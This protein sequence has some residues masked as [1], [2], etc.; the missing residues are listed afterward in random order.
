[1]MMMMMIDRFYTA[2]FSTLEHTYCTSNAFLGYARLI[3][4]FCNPL[5]SDIQ[6]VSTGAGRGRTE[7]EVGRE[8]ERLID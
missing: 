1:M 6:S 3:D 2:L 7:G 4:C 8:R 5:K